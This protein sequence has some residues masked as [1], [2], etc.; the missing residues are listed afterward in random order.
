MPPIKGLGRFEADQEQ[1][2]RGRNSFDHYQALVQLLAAIASSV[3]PHT[4]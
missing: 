2:E 1:Y 3:I 4:I